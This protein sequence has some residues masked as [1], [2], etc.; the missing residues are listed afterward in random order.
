VPGEQ[1]R[2]PSGTVTFLFSDVVGST[3]LWA[4]D[5]EAMSASLRIHDQIFNET[6]AK[7]EGH[8]FST[9]GDSFAAA[10]ARASAA[11]ECAE[12]IQRSLGEVDWG[13]WPALSVRIGLHQGE[14][15][16]RDDNYFGPTVNQ[17][18]RVMAVAHGGQTLLTDGV[19]DASSAMVT[20]LGT[21]TLRDIEASVHLSQ[22][23]THEFPPLSSLGQ[24]IVSLPLPRTSLVGR[25]ES[26]EEV[27]HLIAAHRLVTLVG[28]GGCGKTRLAIEVAHR[29]VPSYP[30]GVWFVDLSAIADEGA[31]PGAL[32]TAL[33]VTISTSSPPI[34]QICTYL[35]NREALLVIDNCEHVIDPSAELV[36]ILLERC[37]QLRI[38][39]TS[40]ESLE[41]DGE[42]TWKVPSL[43]VGDNAPAV[44]LFCERAAAAG[45]VVGEDQGSVA[46]VSEV[47]ERLDGIPLA[48]ELAAARTRTMSVAEI[49][50][51]LDDRFSLLSGGA[52]RSRQ[53]QATLEGAVQWS[54]DLLTADEQL[55]MRTLS[56]FQ[57]GFSVPDVA[58]VAERSESD[59]RQLVD[60]LSAKS[61]V[62][63]TRDATGQVRHRLLETIRLFALARLVD[64]G[65]AETMRNRHLDHFDDQGAS[66]SVA[67]WWAMDEVLRAGREYENFRSAIA[68]AIE[69][70][71]PEA[72]V[73]IAAARFEAASARGEAQL[74]LA[75]LGRTADLSLSDRAYMAAVRVWLL[76]SNGLI[77]EALAD[78]DQAWN[79]GRAATGDHEVLLHLDEG[80]IRGYLGAYDDWGAS[81]DEARRRATMLGDPLLVAGC[82]LFVASH[83]TQTG[84]LDEAID[85]ARSALVTAPHF[86]YRHV[87]EAGLCWSFLEI[88]KVEEASEVVRHFAPIPPGS[89]WSFVNDVMAYLVMAHTD[90]PEVA[91]RALA[92]QTQEVL[93]RRPAI[94]GEFLTGF[95]YLHLLSG[96]PERAQELIESA[97][98]VGL[99]PVAVFIH[100]G[101]RDLTVEERINWMKEKSVLNPVAEVYARFVENGARVV[102]DEVGYWSRGGA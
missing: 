99:A 1:L 69:S 33:S 31:L 86:G 48:I 95:A 72:A 84:R 102:A 44:Q 41:V 9:A 13:T 97:L 82:E 63:V 64:A 80:T 42:F 51:L 78:I 70:D 27:R 87:I 67:R 34:D 57:G 12:A 79:L 15:E 14:A 59:T 30:K 66:L 10:F 54:Y 17:A 94:G 68:W 37:P 38:L 11:V 52:R 74:A 92:R 62:D 77:V 16:E 89:P 45:G 98:P 5:P 24:G 7:C 100:V 55:L 83:L 18:A 73:R 49:R 50:D 21:H 58:V 91:G 90:T 85:V 40:R 43:A 81:I 53:R 47:V 36:D 25:D 93:A 29:E 75:M 4:A 26:V 8:V 96:R 61:L 20:D 88:G 76:I 101:G 19:R 39:A 22:L 35:A 65:E 56:V 6:I 32:A 28:V 46:A 71:R 3:R 60:A 23:G 2:I